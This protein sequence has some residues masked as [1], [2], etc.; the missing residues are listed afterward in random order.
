MQ[1]EMVRRSAPFKKAELLPG[2]SVRRYSGSHD[3]VVHWLEICRH[4][5]LS[6]DYGE[7]DFQN[8]MVERED[9][10]LT[11]DLFFLV[12]EN[13]VYAAT[14]AAFR[15]ANG[16]GYLHMVGL[17]PEYRGKKIGNAISALASERFE[18]Y[19]CP[20]S[21]LSTDD[22]RLGAIKSYLNAG[23]L[24]YIRKGYEEEMRLRWGNVCKEL[25]IGV[26]EFVFE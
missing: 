8:C 18:E 14:F 19:G 1:L 22:F 15:M 9:L 4:G 16:M 26:P 20:L 5:L 13:G 3:E 12:D 11:E 6:E 10:V 23:F 21:F 7:H 2:W 17:K 24:P 25:G